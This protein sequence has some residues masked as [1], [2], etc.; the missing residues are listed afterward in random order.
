MDI[1]ALNY[2]EVKFIFKILQNLIKIILLRGFRCADKHEGRMQ[3]KS[4]L[5]LLQG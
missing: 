3:I 4:R 1:D 2:L 5:T